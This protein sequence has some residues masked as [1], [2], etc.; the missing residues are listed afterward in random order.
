MTTIQ[1]QLQEKLA[2]AISKLGVELPESFMAAVAISADLRFGDYQSNVAMMLKKELG[3]NP[4]E[5]AADL[6]ANLELGELAT[7]DIAGP[8]FINFR[9]TQ[10]AWSQKVDA[11]IRDTRH[12]VPLVAELQN[13]V[14]DFSAPNVAKP[15]HVGHIRS[16]IIGDSLSRISTFLG[17]NVTTDNHIGDWGTQFGM[18]T[19]GWKNL[20]DKAALEADPLQE[21]LRIYRAVNKLC[22]EDEAVKEECKLEL[23]KLQAGDAENTEIWNQCVDVSK[24]GLNAIYDR[25]DVNFDHWHGES[26]YNDELA[27]LVKALASEGHARESDGA[28]CVFSDESLDPKQDPFKEKRG[29]AWTDLPMIVRKADGAF[30]YAT[31]DIATVDYRLR[32]WNADKIW[33][34]VDAR[35]ALHFRQLFDISVRRGCS[36]ELEH[37][38]F[39]TIL[40]KDGKPLKTRDGD[41]PQL[42]DVLDDAIAASRAVIEDKSDHLSTD[43]KEE[44]AETIGIGSVKFTELSH[45]RNSDYIFDLEKMVAL[46]GDTAPYLQ[47]SRVRCLS[48][49]R[50]L[51]DEIDFSSI[52]AQITEDGEVSLARMLARYGEILP[53]V[54]DDLRPNILANYL[55]ELARSFHSFF[56][57]CPVL[58][59]EG[60]TKLTRLALCELTSRILNHGLSLL[61][62]KTPDRM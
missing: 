41:L 61:G 21:L 55:L 23:V 17:Y 33:Y 54:L 3:R 25:L 31:T 29:D 47:Y 16:T 43:E 52:T 35:Q 2:Q 26:Y 28:M 48:I 34:V 44:L 39:G 20:L 4:R 7:A 56:E 45:N 12:G 18:I 50:K 15:M 53:N 37:V 42:G 22:K 27:P 10:G 24:L 58:K 51:D 30:N 6:V 38:T 9:V 11:L 14:V 57:A 8:G 60:E 49:F 40:G 46:Q 13:I 59:S 36:A 19:Y 5:I 1:G 62:I 32:E